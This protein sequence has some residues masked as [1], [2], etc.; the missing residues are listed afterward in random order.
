MSTIPLGEIAR[1]LAR[2]GG[3]TQDRVPCIKADVVCLLAKEAYNPAAIEGQQ[4]M[5]KAAT[6][7]SKCAR[8]KASTL[9]VMA[10]Q[11][12]HELASARPPSPPQDP[13]A[14]AARHRN[15]GLAQPDHLTTEPSPTTQG[16]RSTVK[17]MPAE[18]AGTPQM[19]PWP[20]PAPYTDVPMADTEDILNSERDPSP[21]PPES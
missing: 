8:T 4:R 18:P 5:K 9:M 1:W 14:S 7:G 19:D 13:A 6:R 20:L 11:L 10:D 12:D 15:N 3:L 2:C 21:G 17:A 16:A